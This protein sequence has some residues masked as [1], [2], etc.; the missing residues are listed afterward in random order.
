[1]P[2]R[3]VDYYCLHKDRSEL[4]FTGLDLG[5]LAWNG[6][7]LPA[8]YSIPYDGAIVCKVDHKRKGF[9]I[10]G[11]VSRETL[12]A[13]LV[14]E[15][16]T[17]RFDGLSSVEQLDQGDLLDFRRK[18]AMAHD[19][20]ANSAMMVFSTTLM[21]VLPTGSSATNLTLRKAFT[22]AELLYGSPTGGSR[23]K[24]GGGYWFFFEQ[25]A[26]PPINA[27]D[28]NG[29]ATVKTIDVPTK[30]GLATKVVVMGLTNELMTAAEPAARN[31]L[32]FQDA[33]SDGLI[34]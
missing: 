1:M 25:S 10:F 21:A 17:V 7:H 32:L 28:E 23:F 22:Q 34:N 3:Q 6:E 12:M 18:M 24:N 30:L 27:S 19:N 20:R 29:N 15:G 5:V 14:G 11:F 31:M 2:K 26:S 9:E 33:K 4:A 16:L 8:V 13:H